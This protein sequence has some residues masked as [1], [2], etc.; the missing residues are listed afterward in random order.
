MVTFWTIKYPIFSDTVIHNPHVGADIWGIHTR[1]KSWDVEQMVHQSPYIYMYVSVWVY[2]RPAFERF[3]LP[4]YLY[5]PSENIDR[6]PTIPPTG[7][8]LLILQTTINSIPMARFYIPF[9]HGFTQ[10][11]VSNYR[12]ETVPRFRAMKTRRP[13]V[14]FF[15]IFIALNPMSC[16]ST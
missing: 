4:S 15:L 5:L 3:G 16:N 14:M 8:I 7:K 10:Q 9:P 2:V 11:I 6:L 1:L 12:L 13:R